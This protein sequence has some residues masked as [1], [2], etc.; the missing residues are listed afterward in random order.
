MRF[1]QISNHPRQFRPE[2][3]TQGFISPAR[4]L[5]TAK[6]NS[7]KVEDIWYILVLIYIRTC[8]EIAILFDS[9]SFDVN[10]YHKCV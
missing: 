8:Q 4:H 9:M 2:K 6:V 5:Q 7:A 10:G 1:S 3:L